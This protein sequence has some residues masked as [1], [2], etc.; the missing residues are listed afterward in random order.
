MADLDKL[1]PVTVHI[2]PADSS[3]AHLPI[4]KLTPL[5]ALWKVGVWD[6][7]LASR[8]QR[9]GERKGCEIYK[10]KQLER[11]IEKNERKEERKDNRRE[12]NIAK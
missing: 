9:Q 2:R 11:K 1:P 3:L 12:R 8:E 6:H 7:G 4:L 5:S 10:E